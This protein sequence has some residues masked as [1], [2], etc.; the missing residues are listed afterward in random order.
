MDLQNKK[1]VVFGGSSGIG[2]ATVHRLAAAGARVTAVSRDPERARSE[3]PDGVELKACD[4]R[5]RDGL[6]ALFA[7]LA[8]LDILVN[9]ATGGKRPAGPF[10]E[11]DLDAFQGA[12]DKLWGY[13]NTVRLGAEHMVEDGA[14]VIV[15]GAPARRSKPGQTAIASVGGAV[16]AFCRSVAPEIY[17]RRINVVSPGII[18]TPMFGPDESKREEFLGKATSRHTI[19]RAGTPDEVAS[20]I[21]FVIENDFV[22]GTTVDVDGGWI[23]S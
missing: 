12:F 15:S 10:L 22:T 11:V 18:N 8:P 3:V 9:A 23:S 4:T 20:A 17:P 5:D 21:Q 13:T 16:E 19:K 1:A 14:I 6:S 7:E 2:L